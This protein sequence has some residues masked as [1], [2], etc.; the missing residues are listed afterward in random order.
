MAVGGY[1]TLDKSDDFRIAFGLY[2]MVDSR[3]SKADKRASGGKSKLYRCTGAI[4]LPG[5]KGASG[6]TVFVRGSR[7]ADGRV[8]GDGG[9]LGPLQLRRTI[10]RK[11]EEANS[12]SYG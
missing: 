4:I 2:V 11:E 5:V 1:Y 7:H 6:C 3:R 12:K 9:E 8:A 10:W